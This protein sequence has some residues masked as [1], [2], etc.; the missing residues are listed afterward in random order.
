MLVALRIDGR[1]LDVR[2]K[3]PLWI[4]CP[5]SDYPEL[6]DLPTRRNRY[7]GALSTH[8]S[9]RLLRPGWLRSYGLLAAAALLLTL[10]LA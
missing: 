5:R 2:D 9:E 7:G 1:Q 8:T 6:D 10:F 3:G 4:V